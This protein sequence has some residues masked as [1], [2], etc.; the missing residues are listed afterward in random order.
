MT[1]R[2]R[3]VR[4]QVSTEHVVR[5]FDDADS[6]AETVAAFLYEGWNQ[7]E[8]LLVVARPENWALVAR[9]LGASGC[10]VNEAALSGR[11]VVLDAATTLAKF[12]RNSRPVADRFEDTLGKLVAR[13][14]DQ[15]G[16]PLRIYGEM[17]DILAEQG[18]FVSAT[19]LERL[20]NELGTKYPLRLLCGYASGH[21]GDPRTADLL[22]E[23]CSAHD[24][25]CATPSDLL[26]S[27]LLADRRQAAF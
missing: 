20:L 9:G 17:V 27:W 12:F 21:F 15:S 5:L 13:L 3:T 7:D 2:E 24:H 18:D 1:R 26:G 11:L 4:G 10:P 22:R 6:L 19:D 16:K 25:A 23:I 8:T 14:C